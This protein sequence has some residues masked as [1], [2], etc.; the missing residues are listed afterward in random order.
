MSW[1][2]LLEAYHSP[3]KWRSPDHDVRAVKKGGLFMTRKTFNQHTERGIPINEHDINVLE[4]NSL[5]PARAPINP[6]ASDR[7]LITPNDLEA[8]GA[9]DSVGNGGE[10]SGPTESPPKKKRENP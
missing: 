1:G 10:G 3:F 9:N 7:L 5:P 2:C 8:N 4:D 6:E